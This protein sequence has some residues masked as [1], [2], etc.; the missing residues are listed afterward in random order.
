MSAKRMSGER[1][2][3]QIIREAVDLF[4]KKGFA[5]VTTREIAAAAKINEATIYKYFTSKEDLFDAVITHFGGIMRERF[6]RVQLDP[7]RDIGE[8][9]KEFA[10]SIIGYMKKDPRIMRLM[11]FSGLQEHRFAD[12]L[13][14]QTGGEVLKTVQDLI[15]MG[16]AEGQLRDDL[17]PVYMSLAMVAMII[18][19]NIARILILK[20]YFKDLDEKRYIGTI[21]EILLNGI[22]TQSTG[23]KS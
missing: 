22:R 2:R 12:T 1:R 6:S 13:F 21:A 20:D 19:F 11:M 14:R 18:Y 15:R 9:Y 10:E 8:I 5:E 3:E 16:Q 7:N 23:E 4:A 17:D